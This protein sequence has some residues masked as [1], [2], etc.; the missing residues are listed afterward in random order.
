MIARFNSDWKSS[1]VTGC[2]FGEP[3]ALA[4]LMATSSS[5]SCELGAANTKLRRRTRSVSG[6]RRHGQ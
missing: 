3:L 4:D 6:G 1:R 2:D 5:S